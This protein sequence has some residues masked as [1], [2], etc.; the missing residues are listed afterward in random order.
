MEAL[1]EKLNDF[2]QLC[3]YFFMIEYY[4]RMAARHEL[5]DE[6]SKIDERKLY[7]ERIDNIYKKYGVNSLNLMASIIEE[8]INIA[9]LS[10][11]F[12]LCR[13]IILIMNSKFYSLPVF[14]ELYKNIIVGGMYN[15]NWNIGVSGEPFF[16]LLPIAPEFYETNLMV[17]KNPKLDWKILSNE[18]DSFMC[19][20]FRY[21]NSK[22]D[23]EKEYYFKIINI[24]LESTT[25]DLFSHDRYKSETKKVK[26]CNYTSIEEQIEK[27]PD[28]NIKQLIKNRL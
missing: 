15:P 5:D 3:E 22:S 18:M 2:N 6:F 20:V 27:I 26:Y 28:L 14:K 24:A 12:D 10:T 17:Y 16:M 9:Q 25:I 21:L 19:F 11:S 8:D 1:I 7:L 23:Q 13:N 4:D